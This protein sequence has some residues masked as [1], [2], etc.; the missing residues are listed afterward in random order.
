MAG[1]AFRR[2]GCRIVVRIV[3]RTRDVH[4]DTVAHAFQHIHEGRPAI[5]VARL[6]LSQ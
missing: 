2:A 6:L 4:V 3:W 5:R 1:G